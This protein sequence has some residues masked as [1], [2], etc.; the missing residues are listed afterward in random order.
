MET[1]EN[2]IDRAGAGRSGDRRRPEVTAPVPYAGSD[3]DVMKL[4]VG[5]LII[6]IA[7]GYLAGGR[8]SNLANLQIRWAPLA[9]IGFVM[10]L[11]NPP[12]HW[13]LAMLFG[14]FVLLS[15]F[16]FVNRHVLGFWLI[17]IGVGLNFAVI[18]LNSG[19]PVSS[20]ALAA[21][22][23]ENTIGQLTDN[24]DSYV[25]HHLATGDDRALFLG[26]VI[27]LPPPIGQAISVGDIFTYSG[28]VVVIVGGMRR[29]TKTQPAATPE[30]QGV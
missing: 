23:Q 7:V 25:K 17:L 9:I 11:I 18:G 6:S 15:V 5:T 22:G 12:G 30:V 10:Q 20:Q 19:M 8:L 2:L 1:V 29:R 27:A 4:I 16:A 24:A 21:S 14:S 28:V 26:D 13:P 3:T